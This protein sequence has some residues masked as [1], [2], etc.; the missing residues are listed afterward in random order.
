MPISEPRRATLVA[1]LT[2]PPAAGELAAL[3]AAVDWLEVRADLIG[4]LDAAAL[5]ASLPGKRLLYTLRSA[6]EKGAFGGGPAERR[7]RLRA[8]AESYDLVDLEGDRDLTADLLAAV[9][10]E[11]RVVSWHG[12]PRAAR[13]LRAPRGAPD[14]D[15]GRALQAGGVRAA[16]GRG[17][18][19]ARA[20][21]QRA[22]RRPGGLRR[23]RGRHLDAPRRA[24][25][26]RAGGLR[27][28]GRRPGRA[29]PAAGGAAARRLRRC[30]S[31]G[32]SRRSSA[33]SGIRRCTRSRRGCTTPPIARSA[34]RAST[35]RSRRRRSATSG[36]R[37]SRTRAARLRACR[38]AALGDRAVQGQRGGGRRRA[39]PARRAAVGGQHAGA[40]ATACGKARAPT[41]RACSTRSAGAA[42]R[43]RARGWRCVGA[44][45]AGRA[46]ASC[47]R[48][49]ARR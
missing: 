11:R 3:P 23:R 25:P 44:G 9:P 32:R 21:R 45:G 46:P 38:C 47:W 43:S 4:E 1:T 30:P 49:P 15:A 41:A 6:A 36:S 34:S 13:R 29:R 28:G 26:R 24:L 35:C 27:L 7:Q 33:W 20:A 12:A 14:E 40:A 18:A 5:R 2:R 10:A 8:A 39:Q 31:C 22:A 16:A 37:W 19:A 17:A 48:S 42:C